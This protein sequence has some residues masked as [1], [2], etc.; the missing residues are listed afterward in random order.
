M[1]RRLMIVSIALLLSLSK[2]TAAYVHVDLDYEGAS[3]ALGA[4]Y[5]LAK[6]EGLNTESFNDILDHY[7]SAEIASA[8]IWLSKFL[9][10]KALKDEGL[11]GKEENRYYQVILFMVEKRITPRIL[12]IGK[13]MFNHPK[14]HFFYLGPYLYKTCE[15]VMNLCAQFEAIVTNGKKSFSGVNFVQLSPELQQYFDFSK[16]GNVNW[17]EMWDRITNFPTPKWEDFRED[18]KELFGAVSPVNLAIAGEENIRGRVSH[19]FEKLAEAPESLPELIDKA[20]EAFDIIENLEALRVEE[21]LVGDLFAPDAYLKLFDIGNYNINNYINDYLSQLRGTFYTQWWYIYHYENSASSYYTQNY[22]IKRNGEKLYNME[23]DSR[24]DKETFDKKMTEMLATYKRMY[25]DD[26]VEMTTESRVDK[27]SDNG[28]KHEVIDYEALFDS[29]INHEAVFEKEFNQRIKTLMRDQE[30]SSPLLRIEYKIGKGEK[31]YYEYESAE[32]VRNIGS[33]SFSVNCHDEVELSKGGFNFKVNERY[34]S[35]KMNEYAY[36]PDMVSN[37]EPED[38]TLWEE[39]MEDLEGRIKTNEDLIEEYSQQID[40]LAAAK[41]TTSNNSERQRLDNQIANLNKQI[42]RLVETNRDLQDQLN[43]INDIYEEY[44]VDYTEDL[45]GPYRIPTLENELAGDFHLH[46][47]GPGSWSGHTYT[48]L[49]HIVGMENGVKF[50][51]EVS[52]QRREMRF[53]GIR[54]HRAIIGVEYRL[55]SEYETSEVVD[56]I[57]FTD[58]ISDQEKAD[59]INN[60]RSEI[61]NEY[62]SCQVSVV[63]NEKDPPEKETEEEAFH[64]LWMSD[65][66]ALARFIEYRLRQIDGQLAFIERYLYCSR[67]AKNEFKKAF[68]QPVPRWRTSN[69]AG[70]ALQRWLDNGNG[71]ASHYP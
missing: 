55:V 71:V 12:R 27:Y 32:T 46:W 9:E 6:A 61:Q 63:K 52:Q 14:T 39:K 56:V 44:Q 58:D 11:F 10:R 7:T 25:P 42:N 31:F 41:D 19:I 23:Y 18:F 8:G 64:L 57:D 65:R 30:V 53:L 50:I 20:K 33:A 16:L 35:S 21:A 13:E 15:D 69:P 3:M 62:P 1:K 51:A 43:D 24:S 37:K 67:N 59:L 47:D 40:D 2:A 36:P 54:Y 28:N 17:Q 4:Y 22:V 68:L 29:R 5:A 38:L 70:A 34:N 48:R 49:A 66:L 60:R 45:D 26:N